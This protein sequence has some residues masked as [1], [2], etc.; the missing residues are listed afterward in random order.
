MDHLTNI[1]THF[2]LDDSSRSHKSREMTTKSWKRTKKRLE[3]HFLTTWLVNWQ[4]VSNMV[5]Y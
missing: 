3:E 2:K 4:Q 1:L 5:W